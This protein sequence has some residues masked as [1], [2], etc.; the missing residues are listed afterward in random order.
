[1]NRISFRNLKN[2]IGEYVTVKK[3]N[4][5]LIGIIQKEWDDKVVTV[6]SSDKSTQYSFDSNN[7]KG[8]IFYLQSNIIFSKKIKFENKHWDESCKFW[9]SE[10]V[11]LK[12]F[13]FLKLEKAAGY[14]SNKHKVIKKYRLIL[15]K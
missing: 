14:P 6:V 5:S 12:Y 4:Q 2:H 9:V 11:V 15:N 8:Y 13:K 3:D 10:I 1:M 7:S